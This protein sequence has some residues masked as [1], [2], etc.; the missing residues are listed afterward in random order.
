[1]LTSWCAVLGAG[2]MSHAAPVARVAGA[3]GAYP[4]P[5][6]PRPYRPASQA[7]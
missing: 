1:M 7:W 6:S 2:D 4:T 3:T 5:A